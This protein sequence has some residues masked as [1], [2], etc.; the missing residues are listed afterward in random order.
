MIAGTGTIATAMKGARRARAA[1]W[2]AAF[3]DG[4]CGYDIGYRAMCIAARKI[5]GRIR[6]DVDDRR[7][8]LVREVMKAV[9]VSTGDELLSWAYRDTAAQTNTGDDRNREN[10]GAEKTMTGRWDRIASL[11]PAVM[12][13]AADGD[14]DAKRI[15]SE[16]AM[17]LAGSVEAAVRAYFML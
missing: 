5:D 9:G 6:S 11:A 3:G 14:D 17:E 15:L 2:G 4:G 12:A 13:A 16:S 7:R 1:G 10:D 8:G